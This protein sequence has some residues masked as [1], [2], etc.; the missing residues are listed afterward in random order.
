MRKM[1]WCWGTIIILLPLAA[2]AADEY[3]RQPLDDFEE[4][5]A[6]I[7]GDPTTDLTQR[8][9]GL[10]PNTEHVKQGK[11]SLAFMIRVD[12]SERPGVKY[13]KGWPMASRKLDPPQDWSAFDRV[14][15]WLYTETE[16]TLPEPAL[17]CG[18]AHGAQK[19]VQWYPVSGIV[20]NQWQQHSILLTSDQDWTQ[21]SGI[22]FYIAEAWYHD[23]DRVNFYFDDMRLAARKEPRLLDCSLCA[24]VHPRGKQ[25][26][27]HVALEGPPQG[28][29]LHGEVQDLKGRRQ[30]SFDRAPAAKRESFAVDLAG[31]PAGSHYLQ[32]D[33]LNAAGKRVDR[34]RTFF[35]SLEPGT[36][37]YLSLITFYTHD[38]KD[39]TPERMQLLND[40]A[41][42]AVAMKLV[43]GYDTGP[44]PTVEELRPQIDMVKQNLKLDPWPWVFS[45]RFI[46][47]PEDARGHSGLGQSSPDY[48]KRINILDLD[49]AA[50]ARRDMLDLWR[51]A[52]KLAKE[53]QAPGI[54]MDLEAYNNYRAYSVKYVAEKRGESVAQVIAQC[55]Q[56]GADLAKI[57]EQEYPQCIV[58]SLFSHTQRVHKLPGYDGPVYSTA[59]HITLGFLKYCKA[60]E[61]PAKYL[62][63]GETSPG[64]Y[65]RNVEA[66]KQKI[67]RRDEAMAHL[68][69]EFPDHFF[70]AGTISPYHDY[71]ILTS[72]IKQ[73]AGD[74]PE[75]KTI[76]DFEPMFRTLFEAYDWV[77]IYASSAA[78]TEPYKAENSK[79]YSE[80]L[81]RALEAAAK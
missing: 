76:A 48:F 65:N 32:L 52:V 30:S 61:L 6:W 72:W 57:I 46:G 73:R 15:F 69:E 14:D 10:A 13:A 59:G 12:W 64:Y 36:R 43:G 7:K 47:R 55:E 19:P 58:W 71:K 56:V 29:K 41:Y 80:V 74:D 63:G 67:A 21:V 16:A 39:E 26:E 60:H 51:L 27:V 38:L 40:S 78:K 62:C 33:V 24:R 22:Y 54:V 70:L 1:F 35:R 18:F 49:N 50:G 53:W 34:R 11:Q 37:C 42:A 44:V 75:L 17:K 8:E 4:L 68:L 28:C 45:N 66:L 25:G 2:R 77:W 9:V 79:L 5:S 23:K 81:S 20:P 3:V 31:V